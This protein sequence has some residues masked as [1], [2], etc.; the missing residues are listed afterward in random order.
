[1]LAGKRFLPSTQDRK[2]A[3][4]NLRQPAKGSANFSLS[5]PG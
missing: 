1:M 2:P 4:E 5:R 3:V